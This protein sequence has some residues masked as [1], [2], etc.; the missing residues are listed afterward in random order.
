MKL[1]RYNIIRMASDNRVWVWNTLKGSKTFINSSLYDALIA[2]TAPPES[3]PMK[4]LASAGIV[5]DDSID[6]M[7]LL[8]FKYNRSRY[9]NKTLSIYLLLSYAC[10]MRCKYCFQKGFIHSE[11][12]CTNISDEHIVNTINFIQNY[13]DRYDTDKLQITFYGGEPLLQ[14]KEIKQFKS[15]LD[16][17][18]NINGVAIE[19]DMFTNG[20]HL[21]EHVP[22]LVD[23]KI[24]AYVTIDGNPEKHNERRP[25][26]D[27]NKS[28]NAI[29]NG[30][31]KYSHLGQLRINVVCDSDNASS[32]EH[33]PPLL[34]KL[35]RNTHIY[36]S[37]AISANAPNEFLD[38]NK[39]ESSERAG[40]STVIN[41]L[42][43]MGFVATAFIE[44]QICPALFPHRFLIDLLGDMYKCNACAGHKKDFY[45]G[46]YKNMS[47]NKLES[48]NY[49]IIS[50]NAWQNNPQCIECALLPTCYGGCMAQ[51]LCIGGNIQNASCSI[52]CRLDSIVPLVMA[53]SIS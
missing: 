34:Q 19:Y 26:L 20:Y 45:I 43:S 25:L 22:Y 17:L 41:N 24:G 28:F 37:P 4:R 2:N 13:I 29:L 30:C 35:S 8:K 33:L 15:L 3:P 40:L 7:A 1:S 9:S 6:E 10:N 36:L 32:L 16:E 27:G 12:H 21:L 31:I 18:A 52:K 39:M 23:E 49:D 53:Q 11:D 42:T 50:E 51:N 44:G 47:W 48:A 14:I 38:S 46:N 5:V